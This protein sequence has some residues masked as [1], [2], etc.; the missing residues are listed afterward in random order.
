[1]FGLKTQTERI[2][3]IRRMAASPVQACGRIRRSPPL[4]RSTSFSDQTEG[5]SSAG[6][7][8]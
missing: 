7:G 4:K 1:M 2:A 5:G 6:R 3:T 8:K